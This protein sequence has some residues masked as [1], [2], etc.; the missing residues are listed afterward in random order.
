M[1][2]EYGEYRLSNYAPHTSLFGVY[3]DVVIT[4]GT[5]YAACFY[6]WYIGVIIV[7]KRAV[8]KN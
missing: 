6:K 4:G 1:K 2:I 8:P 5:L 3:S 7:R